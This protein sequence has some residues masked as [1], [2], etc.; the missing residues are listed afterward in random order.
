LRIG[1]GTRLKI[2]EAMAMG[3]AV[4]S[5][6]V[7]AEGLPVHSGENI[8]LADTPQDF[9]AAVISLLGNPVARKR[10]GSAARILVQEN[11]SWTKVAEDFA[12]TLHEVTAQPAVR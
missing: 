6:S 1:G 9:A 7:G 12:R 2:F 3:K 10:M 11:Y 5:T 8:L 4:V